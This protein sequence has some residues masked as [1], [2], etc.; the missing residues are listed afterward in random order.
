M[1]LDKVRKYVVIASDDGGPAALAL[2]MVD[3]QEVVEAEHAQALADLANMLNA[4]RKMVWLQIDYN[5]EMLVDLAGEYGY[6]LDSHE[7]KDEGWY[8]VF[9]RNVKRAPEAAKKADIPSSN[10]D[11]EKLQKQLEKFTTDLSQTAWVN[12]EVTN[13]GGAPQVGRGSSMGYTAVN[14]T[15]TMGFIE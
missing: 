12:Y 9:K 4:G 14:S 11:L 8:L 13:I 1:E 5:P 7:R 3:P 6:E 10:P 15:S 2:M